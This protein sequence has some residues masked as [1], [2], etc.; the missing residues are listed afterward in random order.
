MQKHRILRKGIFM[1]DVP[2]IKDYRLLAYFQ[3]LSADSLYPSAGS[4]SAITAAHAAALF[5]MACRVN[6]RKIETSSNEKIEKEQKTFWQK[7]LFKADLLLEQSLALAQE[8]GFA[9]KNFFEGASKGAEKAT[10]VPLQIAH[11]AGEI[12]TLIRSAFP[13][14]YAPVRADIECARCL[15]EGSKKA[16]LTVARYNL[17]LLEQELLEDYTKKILELEQVF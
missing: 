12:I 2:T 16:A 6:L 11:C 9:I 1:K 3:E 5:A 15:A 14:S 17:Q 4:S 13:R 10:T 7:T 8:D